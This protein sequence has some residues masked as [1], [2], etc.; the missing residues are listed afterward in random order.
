MR[1]WYIKCTLGFL[2]FLVING[3][4]AFVLHPL[5]Y[6]NT[7]AALGF[8]LSVLLS[9]P[10]IFALPTIIEGAIT[11]KP[12]SPDSYSRDGFGPLG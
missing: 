4:L 11:G 8:V 12:P 6:S 1:W 9:I 10:A 3:T 2:A 7:W 5:R